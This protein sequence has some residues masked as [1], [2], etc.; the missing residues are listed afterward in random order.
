MMQESLW[1][2]TVSLPQFPQLKEDTK[3]DV[4]IIGGGITGILCAYMLE[5]EGVSYLLVE[6]D[7]ICSSV[8]QNTTAK[9]TLQHGLIYD[10]L[11]RRFGIEK[12]RMYLQANLVA[13]EQFRILCS[14]IECHYEV[15]DSFV[16]S[17]TDR[18]ELEQE[19]RAYDLLGYDA[20]YLEKLSLPMPTAGAVKI[21]GQAQFHPLEFL[22][23]ISQSLHIFEHT[24][25]TEL[26]PHT[27]VTSH[28]CITADRIVVATHFPIVNKHGAYFL[29]MYQSCSYVLALEHAQ[30]VDGMYIDG[31]GKGLSFR[32]ADG[33]LLLGGGDHRT[34]TCGGGY[35]VLSQF[36][37]LHYPAACEKYRWFTQDCMT[38]D[39][40]PYIGLYGRNTPDFYVAAGFHKWGMTSSM[41]AANILRDMIMGRENPY[42]AI[43]NPHRT[44]LRPQLFIN[45]F[46]ATKNLLS[47]SRKRC[48]H[49]GC[50]LKWNIA[51]HSWDCP[52]HGSRF[53]ETGQL[54]NNPATDDLKIS[55]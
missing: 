45:A 47:F 15:K 33:L 22:Q 18:R 50:A 14:D 34:G 29:K 4:L 9:I 48:P 42:A 39:Q 28:G 26:G 31:N 27:A 19:Q 5:Q 17:L 55:K 7:R 38:L 1:R 37:D 51:Q 10:K 3:T 49:M 21:S 46:E 13:L 44:M 24:K 2:D 20:D 23:S 54:I 25:V 52:C 16:Y 43:Y 32:N 6:A 11:I 35:Q 30:N 8:T 36:A 41:I 53:T 12:A 40:V